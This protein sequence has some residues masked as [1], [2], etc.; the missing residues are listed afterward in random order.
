MEVAGESGDSVF[1]RGFGDYERS[2]MKLTAAAHRGSAT[3][4]T[5]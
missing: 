1:L 3:S 5:G 4:P 2:S